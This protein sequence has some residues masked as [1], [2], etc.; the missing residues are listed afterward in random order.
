MRELLPQSPPPALAVALSGGPDSTALALLAREWSAEWGVRLLALTVDHGLRQASAAE[1][2][3][4][5]GWCVMRGLE[6]TV[7][8]WSGAPPVS[9]LQASARQARYRLLA[10]ACRQRGV[11]HLLLGHQR[12]DQIE[13]MLLRLAAGSGADGAAGMSAVSRRDG[14]WLLRPLLAWPRRAVLAVLAERGETSL[15]DPSNRARRFARARL[16]PVL[17][18]APDRLV[19]RLAGAAQ[20]FG[21]LRQVWQAAL[22]DASRLVSVEPLGYLRLARGDFA[23]L[24]AALRVRL[25]AR[26]LHCL[27]GHPH[28]PASAAV[29][30]LCARLSGDG[31]VAASLAGCVLRAD[32]GS[33]L[34]LREL[35]RLP[36]PGL[37]C[38]G[39]ELRWDRFLIARSPGDRLRGQV[40]V[41]AL[42]RR[43]WRSV[44]TAGDRA[45]LSAVPA[46]VRP[47]LLAVEDAGGL[48]GLPQ[49]GL[50]RAEL[51]EPAIGVR[52]Q[53]VHE[54]VPDPFVIVC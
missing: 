43:A 15:D 6:P 23:A 30:R 53:P 8:R 10:E 33:V 41:G 25:L 46:A 22:R 38:P 2:A 18:A 39:A 51:G 47:G 36:P 21:R 19:E 42:G 5:A 40:R 20:A 3:A 34:V 49:L 37:L 4:V 31:R 35:R 24:P 45:R 48:A 14:L 9:G 12:D 1:A 32:H 16:R 27:G 11:R 52:F 44:L 7:L 28:A 26:L 13:T 54:L 29:V 17:A 50:W